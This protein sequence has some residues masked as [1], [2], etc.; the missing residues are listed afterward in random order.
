MKIT[1]RNTLLSSFL[2]LKSFP[3]FLFVK[4]YIYSIYI[5]YLNIIV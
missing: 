5:Y 2:K 1:Q 4:F 3:L